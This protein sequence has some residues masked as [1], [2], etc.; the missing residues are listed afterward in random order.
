MS[1][2]SEMQSLRKESIRRRDT[3]KEGRNYRTNLILIWSC[4]N[5]GLAMETRRTGLFSHLSIKFNFVF[6][7]IS[8]K[9][10]ASLD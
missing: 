8:I 1:L 9:K 3:E 7:C 5:T 6:F 10:R 4:L 2:G